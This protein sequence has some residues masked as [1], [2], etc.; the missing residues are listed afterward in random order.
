M[1]EVS[2]G[3]RGSRE[4]KCAVELGV[5]ERV[6]ALWEDNLRISDCGEGVGATLRA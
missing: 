6:L 4:I 1:T 2:V 3:N 5:V